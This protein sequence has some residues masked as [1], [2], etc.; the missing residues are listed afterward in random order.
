MPRADVVEA[1]AAAQ[2]FPY[3]QEGPPTAQHFVGARHGAELSVS[4]HA[5]NL[6]RQAQ[7]L[8][9]G[10]WSQTRTRVVETLRI[11]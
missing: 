7:P 9:Y 11:A 6:A 5:D 3:D 1:A 2:D 10:F 4:C 8:R